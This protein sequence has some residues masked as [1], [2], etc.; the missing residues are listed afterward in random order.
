MDKKI[1]KQKIT[2][3]QIVRIMRALVTGFNN[4][5]VLF[6]LAGVIT[7]YSCEQPDYPPLPPTPEPKPKPTPDKTFTVQSLDKVETDKLIFSIDSMLNLGK[8]PQVSMSGTY[9]VGNLQ[10]PNVS[11]VLQALRKPNVIADINNA[12]F[13]AGA[14]SVY[15]GLAMV[16][17]LA[18]N[19]IKIKNESGKTGGTDRFFF[20]D[21]KNERYTEDDYGTL[22]GITSG[23]GLRPFGTSDINFLHIDIYYALN[24][25]L[26]VRGGGIQYI[27]ISFQKCWGRF[28]K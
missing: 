7:L 24:Y 13:L 18:D 23:D 25:E 5:Q 28:Q 4:T 12:I 2:D 20:I 15:L 22:R 14:D 16:K 1:L 3:S 9:D 8:K 19:N 26:N 11:A 27:Y 21:N 10:M 17:L 6:V